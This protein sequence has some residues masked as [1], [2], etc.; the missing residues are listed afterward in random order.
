VYDAAETST[1]FLTLQP[2][3]DRRS[4]RYDRIN[5]NKGNSMTKQLLVLV[6][7]LLALVGCAAPT[8]PDYAAQYQ[9]ILDGYLA[10]W[11]AG[12]IDGLDAVLALN[13]HRRSP[14]GLNSDDLATMKKVMTDFR[15]SYPD[16][17]VVI[18]E[19]HFMKELSFVLWTA[20]GT[21]TGPGATPPT[22][23][24]IKVSGASL[25]R[26]QDGTMVEELA[27]FDALNMQQQLGFTPTPP[28]SGAAPAAK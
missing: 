6:V 25:G 13:F 16:F 11:N 15:T 18:D 20:T 24:S 26:Y 27:Y 28:A 14:G 8:A 22:G 21:N 23:K 12:N 10:G 19:S 2:L 4:V 5:K 3:G 9:P 1:G 7:G 17:K